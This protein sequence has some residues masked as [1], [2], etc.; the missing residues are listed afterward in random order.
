VTFFTAQGGTSIPAL[1]Q[2]V[3]TDTLSLLFESASSSTNYVRDF[4]PLEAR[5]EGRYLHFATRVADPYNTPLFVEGLS[6]ALQVH[7]RCRLWTGRHSQPKAE[8]PT[9]RTFSYFLNM[10]Q[11]IWIDSSF[12]SRWVEVILIHILKAGK[13]CFLSPLTS[14]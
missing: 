4:L 7:P 5:E 9:P 13:D 12:T 6:N 14:I 10:C 3:V 8:A 2:D 1:S 11:R